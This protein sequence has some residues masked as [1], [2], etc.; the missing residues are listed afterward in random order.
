MIRTAAL[1]LLLTL[2]PAQDAKSAVQAPP[3]SRLVPKEAFFVIQARNLDALRADFEAGAWYG[4]YH[5]DEL[6]EMR[7]WVESALREMKERTPEGSSSVDPWE[8]IQSVHGSAT[9]FGVLRSGKKNYRL[10]RV[11]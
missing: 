3:L 2:Q 5:D 7:G 8:C 6:K 10:V 9:A 1:A 11:R 4:L